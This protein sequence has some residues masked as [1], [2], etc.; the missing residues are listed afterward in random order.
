MNNKHIIMHIVG[1]RPQFIKLAPISRELRNNNYEEVIIH[2]GQHYDENMSDVFFREL[3]IPRPDVNLNIGS[4]THAQMTSKAMVE[5]ESVV[6]KYN[7]KIV[8]LYGDTNSTLAAALVCSKLNIH[9]AHVEAGPRTFDKSNPEECNRIITDHLSTLLFCPDKI[10][11][12]NLKNEGIKKGVYFTG[13]VMYDAFLYSSS[14]KSDFDIM[15]L[16]KLKFNDYIL[17]TWHRQENTTS[18]NI[19]KS[20]INFIERINY[21]IILP[22]HPRTRKNLQEFNLWQK[23]N[24]LKN[25]VIIAP[26]GYI[27]TVKLLN[28]C[29]MVITDSGGLSKESSFAGVRCLFMLKLKP[30]PDLIDLGWI[31]PIDLSNEDTHKIG[32]NFIN[33]SDNKNN[34]NYVEFY[35]DGHASEKIVKILIENKYL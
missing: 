29:K 22:L 4:G 23:I 19:M 26:I 35:G 9:I 6:L 2:T 13:D 28:N 18:E 20:I 21:K 32:Y 16:Y 34:C 31:C 25:V 1:N 24:S 7:P 3:D 12:E 27:E 14:K 17:M 15:S 10:S 30:W 8:L 11:V 33:D 5:I